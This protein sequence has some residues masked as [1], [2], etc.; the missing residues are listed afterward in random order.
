L[1][2]CLDGDLATG[3][4]RVRISELLVAELDVDDQHYVV[5]EGEVYHVTAGFLERLDRRLSQVTWSDF[6]YPGYT[7]GNEPDYLSRRWRTARVGSP[8][9]TGRNITLPGQ[10]PF[11]PCDLVTDDG[12]LTFAKLKGRSS[13]FSHLCSQVIA[14][15]EML[16]Q[17]PA[18]RDALVRRVAEATD[19][20][21]IRDVVAEGVAR[22]AARQPNSFQLCLL[23]LG[24]WKGQPDVRHLPLVS[25]LILRK[26]VERL[27]AYGFDVEFA[28]PAT[29]PLAARGDQSKSAGSRSDM[30]RTQRR[31]RP[32]PT[33][34]L[35]AKT[36][37]PR[38]RR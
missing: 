30:V 29:A 28:S 11:E 18:A 36:A 31:S 37:H 8:C 23:L 6:P 4:E 13:T 35:T 21:K 20:P 22:L 5:S 9:S 19:N 3:V 33:P 16:I 27:T 12:T 38:T 15:T 32:L 10:T 24:T 1:R 17:E 25:R 2:A 26:T 14:A 7:G 34:D